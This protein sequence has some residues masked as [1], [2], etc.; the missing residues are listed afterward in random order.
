MK[1]LWILLITFV[2]LAGCT[3]TP[4][5][6]QTKSTEQ[7]PTN[8]AVAQN[9]N[10][11]LILSTSYYDPSIDTVGINKMTEDVTQ[12]F[13]AELQPLLRAAGKTPINVN[14]KSRKY[15]A[16]QR[17]ALHSSENNAENVVLLEI[18]TPLS[19]GEYAIHLRVRYFD[20]R[21]VVRDGVTSSVIPTNPL[22]RSYLLKGPGAD[23][24]LSW[25]KVAQRFL[26]DLKASGRLK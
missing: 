16:G 5:Q 20:L 25:E 14:D 18:D 11:V 3:A 23:S 10:R 9:T 13:S 22:E 6:G 1:I 4:Q 19:N 21:Y 26:T 15:S 2:S 12:A 7:T 24:N 17:L 8:H